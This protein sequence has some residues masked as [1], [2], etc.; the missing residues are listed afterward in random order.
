MRTLKEL[1]TLTLEYL[2]VYMGKSGI[3]YTIFKMKEEGIISEIEHCEL[4]NYIN[5][6]R[7]NHW[8]NKDFSWRPGNIQGRKRW[9]K[10][11]IKAIEKA[12]V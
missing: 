5:C 7:P 8:N 11:Q 12:N 6:Y 1:F 4:Y 3:C 10:K 9:I 2:P